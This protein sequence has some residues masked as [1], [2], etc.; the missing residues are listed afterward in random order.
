MIDTCPHCRTRVLIQRDGTCPSC[1]KN[2]GAHATATPAARPGSVDAEGPLTSAGD[3]APP[4]TGQLVQPSAD[5]PAPEGGGG[6][7]AAPLGPFRRIVPTGE[8]LEIAARRAGTIRPWL[9]F[10]IF[11]AMLVAGAVDRS[12]RQGL[13]WMFFVL[14]PSYVI[15]VRRLLW[16][17]RLTVR[18]GRFSIRIRGS[19]IS[20]PASNVTALAID[21]KNLV[22]RFADVE[23]VNPPRRRRALVAQ[24]EKFAMHVE[25]PTEGITAVEAERVQRALGIQY[26]DPEGRLARREEFRR[27][28]AAL[29]SR[30]WVT[31]A[32]IGLNVAVF[33]AMVL[34]GLSPLRP[35]VE[36]MV[37]WGADYGPLTLSGEKWRLLTNAFLHFGVLHLLFNM[38]ALWD[39]GRLMERLAGN[40]G[41]AILYL[42]S[43]LG[44]SLA[45]VAAHPQVVSAGASGAI[46]GLFGGLLAFTLRHR[47]WIPA[48][49]LKDLRSS[50]I[51]FIVFNML[52][53]GFSAG[54]DVMAHLGGLAA[55]FAAGCVMAWGLSPGAR[56]A[57]PAANLSTA[58]IGGVAIVLL[59]PMLPPPPGDVLGEFRRFAT[60]EESA[61]KLFNS[62]S[63]KRA[64]G[65]IDD[66]R[67]AEIVRDE[68][69]PPWRSAVERF[70]SLKNVPAESAR[71]VAA[72][73][74]YM[75][76]RTES[77]EFLVKVGSA[78][79]AKAVEEFQAKWKAA[80]AAARKVGAEAKR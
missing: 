55:G 51:G 4:L 61:I 10:S 59:L 67:L 36:A 74:E 33:I 42:L 43:G 27:T 53:A 22:L 80:E 2:T 14:V 47:R 24:A 75:R 11:L 72:L 37:R 13:V 57:R 9:F 3:G 49:E 39:V 25:T 79:D 71:I 34:S 28:L 29:T 23:A 58:V 12:A 41:M 30:T 35:D 16:P 56:T 38:W 26:F 8:E 31:P 76:L 19:E 63:A 44:A 21:G 60:A 45:S 73:E 64:Q 66:A 40:A 32:I 17:L 50:A 48:E 1:K 62:A 70:Q 68:V 7:A 46:F 6:A 78:V 15:L 18:G 52:F 20:C 65:D 77:W 54:I 5:A 69:L